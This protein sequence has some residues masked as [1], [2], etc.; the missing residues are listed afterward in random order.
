MLLPL[1]RA[2]RSTSLST[3][4]LVGMIAGIGFGLVLPEQ[5]DLLA[6]LGAGFL[7]LFQMPVIPYIVVSIITSIGRLSRNQAASIFRGSAGVLVGFWIL[8]LLV[9]LAFPAGFPDWKSGSFFS[10][11][12]LEEAPELSLVEL[13]IPTNPFTALAETVV[14]SVVLF[15]IAVGIALIGVPENRPVILALQKIGDALL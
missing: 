5:A 12:Q 4:I 11:S 2:Y 14:P 3:K 8:S 13:F 9:V 6:P 15:S 1:W 7:R 10:S